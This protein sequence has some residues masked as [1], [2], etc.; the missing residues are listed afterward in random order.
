M[1]YGQETDQVYSTVPGPA[2]YIG[3]YDGTRVTTSSVSAALLDKRYQYSTCSPGGY[4]HRHVSI[5]T[6]Q[7]GIHFVYFSPE[8]I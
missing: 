7:Q 3:Q 2:W 1:S 8:F 5:L 4:I 6:N